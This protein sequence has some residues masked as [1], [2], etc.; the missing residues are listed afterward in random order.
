MPSLT[1]PPPPEGEQSGSKEENLKDS[2]GGE[3]GEGEDDG[4]NERGDDEDDENEGGDDD[5]DDNEDEDEK[6]DDEESDEKGDDE[7]SDDEE[8]DDEESIVEEYKGCAEELSELLTTKKPS[9]NRQRWLVG[10]HDYLQS[11]DGKALHDKQCLCS[12]Q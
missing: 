3:E 11:L 4:E 12:Q 5:G 8:S 1:I 2:G 7:E 9:T 10:F 6:D